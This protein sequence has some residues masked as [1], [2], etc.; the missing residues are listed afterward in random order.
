MDDASK[1]PHVMWTTHHHTSTRYHSVLQAIVPSRHEHTSLPGIT[2][3]FKQYYHHAMSI[4]GITVCCISNPCR[5][6]LLTVAARRRYRRSPPRPSFQRSDFGFPGAGAALFLSLFCCGSIV[7]AA[8]F[9]VEVEEHVTSLCGA[10]NGDSH[11][12]TRPQ[13]F[14]NLLSNTSAPMLQLV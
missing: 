3:Y 1:L 2:G 6:S 14:S 10:I 4:P 11:S 5:S 8:S 7:S 13:L 9:D 12:L